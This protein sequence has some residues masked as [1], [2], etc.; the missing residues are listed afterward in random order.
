MHD[1]NTIPK[2]PTAM[3][4]H[5]SDGD[6]KR[7]FRLQVNR[8][9]LGFLGKFFGSSST[10]ATNI[11]GLVA[12]VSLVLVVVSFMVTP[13]PEI[14]DARKWLFALTNSALSFIFGAASRK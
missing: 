13:G 11:A 4:G 2:Q 12:V 1:A 10:A 8:Q 14:V 5:P 9:S 7:R 6:S 3:A